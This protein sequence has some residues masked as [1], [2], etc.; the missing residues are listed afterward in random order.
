M[1]LIRG[2]EQRVAT[3]FAEGLISGTMHLALGQEASEAGACM[4]L[5]SDDLITV[6]HRGHGQVLAK[7]AAPEAVLAEILGRV[8]G[9]SGGRGGSLHVGDPSVGALTGI[10]MVGSS[11]PIALGLAFAER[12]LGRDHVVL[13]YFGDGAANKGEVHEAMNLASVW[14]LPV[15]FLCENNFYASTTNIALMMAVPQVADRASAYS[16]PGVVVDGNDAAAVFAAVTAAAERARRSD[17]PSL[18]ECLTYRRGGHKRDAAADYRPAGEVE[19]WLELDPIP[20]FRA[21]LLAEGLADEPGLAVI[22]ADVEREL[23]TAVARALAA[24]PAEPSARPG[25]SQAQG[26]A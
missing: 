22:E 7:G 25:I 8:T 18:I 19:A 26:A 10:A 5:L 11:S 14:R 3:L 20:R 24:P 12:Y 21:R 15:I 6:T 17:G 1:V 4:A 23:E 16:M 2:F 13:N 9:T